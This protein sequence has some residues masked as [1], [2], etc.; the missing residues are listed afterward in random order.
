MVKNLPAN[1]GDLRDMGSIPES[2]RSPGRG[3]G[4]PLQHF[5]WDNP[6]VRRLVGHSP[7]A[8]KR[9]WLSNET[10][11]AMRLLFSSSF[12]RP[13]SFSRTAAAGSCEYLRQL[14]L[15]QVF[16]KR[17]L[18]TWITWEAVQFS[19]VAQS[20][21]TLWDSMSCIPA[22]SSGHGIL[23][24]RILEWVAISFFRGSSRPRDRTHVS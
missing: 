1:A 20:C 19:S 8:C 11:T 12:L 9:V 3:N 22:G 17:A 6:R 14:L 4:S 18:K 21:P 13:S 10:A 23:Q 16:P 24:A 5:C 7:W 2:G 15:R